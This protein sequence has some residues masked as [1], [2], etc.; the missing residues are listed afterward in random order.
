MFFYSKKCIHCDPIPAN[1]W[2][3]YE[4]VE[5]F[6]SRFFDFLIVPVIQD[7]IKKNISGRCFEK[8]FVNGLLNFLSLF[9]IIKIIPITKEERLNI[10]N[11]TLVIVDEAEKRDYIIRAVKFLGSPT[12]IFQLS[13]S[14]Y[15]TFF[16]NSLPLLDFTEELAVDFD[17]KCEFKKFLQLHGFPFTTGSSFKRKSI[18]LNYAQKIGFPLVVKPR[19]GSL[20]RHTTVNIK[21][22]K[23]L[24]RAIKIVKIISNEFIVE[25]FIEGK[26]YRVVLIGNKMA[27]CAL[28]E[29]SNVIGDGIHN[30]R[31]L[32]DFKNK[33]KERGFKYQK[34]T[35]LYKIGV[36]LGGYDLFQKSGYTYDFIPKKG[37]KIYLSDKIILT[38]GADIHDVTDKVDPRNIFLFEKISRNLETSL[39][40]FDVITEDISRPFDKEPLIIIEANSNPY[41]DMHHFP[42][43][44]SSRNVASLILD[45]IEKKYGL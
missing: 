13:L 1:S 18:A 32:I 15:K 7:I 39:V 6:F 21:D 28:R 23:E 17:D 24:K 4:R 31:Q 2:H 11:R 43:S 40:G 26:N 30:I 36:D 25:K 20:S 44:G 27:A 22:E 16:F 3:I 19:C 35:T 14:N 41:I 42:S 8:K 37:E 29:S 34:N 5:N 38:T 9:S 10:R 45:E 33:E 12:E